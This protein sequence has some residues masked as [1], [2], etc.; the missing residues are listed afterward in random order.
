V[1]IY[2]CVQRWEKNCIHLTRCQKLTLLQNLQLQLCMSGG[3]TVVC[4]WVCVYSCVFAC[5]CLRV[6]VLLW[7]CTSSFVYPVAAPICVC[8]SARM[9]LSVFVR[10]CVI[11]RVIRILMYVCV[12]TYMY[13]WFCVCVCACFCVRLCLFVRVCPCLCV[14][15]YVCV[16]VSLCVRVCFLCVSVLGFIYTHTNTH[17]H[18]HKYM[19][20]RMYACGYAC[21]YSF[22]HIFVSAFIGYACVRL[23]I[24]LR[25]CVDRQACWQKHTRKWQGDT[26]RERHRIFLHG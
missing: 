5:V 13:M 18:T 20:V 9:Y 6:C 19:Y 11:F 15:V 7:T 22:V 4:V 3:C 2:V 16:R 12:Y 14:C 21:M 23:C 1:Y 25:V 17:T 10:V 24:F 26:R 8:E